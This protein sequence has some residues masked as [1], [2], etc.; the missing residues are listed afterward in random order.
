MKT[1]EIKIIDKGEA[2]KGWRLIEARTDELDSQ[3]IY[4]AVNS[5]EALI[6]AARYTLDN[7][8]AGYKEKIITAPKN[9]HIQLNESIKILEKAIKQAEGK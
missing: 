1:K 5:H 7:L 6:Q 2:R 9:F 4:R 8:Y 3:A